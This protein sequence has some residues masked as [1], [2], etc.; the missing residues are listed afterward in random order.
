MTLSRPFIIKEKRALL[1]PR[2]NNGASKSKSNRTYK[3]LNPSAVA[4][5]TCMKAPNSPAAE[6][7]P[8]TNEREEIDGVSN[9]L[10]R[11]EFNF[12]AAPQ[13]FLDPPTWE[14]MLKRS[15]PRSSVRENDTRDTGNI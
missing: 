2:T 6:D 12:S 9:R 13:P 15:R 4:A 5:E 10:T 8:A 1:P 3:Q 14:A 7:E 11:I